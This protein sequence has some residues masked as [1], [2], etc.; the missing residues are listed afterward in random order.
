MKTWIAA[1]C[2]ISTTAFAQNSEGPAAPVRRPVPMAPIS[3]ENGAEFLPDNYLV[4]LVVAEKEQAKTELSVVVATTSA[5]NASALDT[6]LNF[7]GSLV[8]QENGVM[9]VRYVLSIQVPV[10]EGPS[11]NL[12]SSS[13]NAS[14]RMRPGET[15]EIFK[16]GTM[17]YKLTVSKLAAE[18]G[19]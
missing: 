9:L 4:K 10:T 16:S 11:S 14:V 17:S 7:G 5:F 18:K 15:V 6:T 2:L 1:L 3:S 12:R 8:P 13:C 19:K